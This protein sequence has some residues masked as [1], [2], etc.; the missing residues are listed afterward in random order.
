MKILGIESSAGPASCAVVED[1]KILAS[2]YTNQKLTHSQTL[3]PMICDM[4]KNA[5]LTVDDIDLFAV[6]A[7][8]GSFTGV[9][10]G[11]AAAKGLAFP[12][13]PCA[14]IPTLAAIAENAA[15]LSFNGTVCAAMDARCGQI[16][17]AFWRAE[18]GKLTRLA[19]DAAISV[20]E[21]G[22]Q[23]AAQNQPALLLGDGAN[24]CYAAWRDKLDVTLAPPQLLY[25]SA[26]AVA[27][28]AAA[29]GEGAVMSA[30]E[31][32]PIYLR[33]PQAERERLAKN[34]L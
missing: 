21:A 23:L 32:R 12:D 15:G 14:R 4:L 31:L 3:V 7:G 24:L 18:N 2:A 33:L 26:A 34:K 27:L 1:G 10:I 9:R 28:L 6:S 5:A 22:T 19:A 11:I 17:T 20:E 13:K 30:N 8:P 29:G 25:Q 16:Y